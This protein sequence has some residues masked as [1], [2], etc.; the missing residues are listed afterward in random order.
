MDTAFG[1]FEEKGIIRRVRTPAGAK[2]YGQPIGT[3][4][5]LDA[6]S[7]G[8]S[9][10]GGGSGTRKPSRAVSKPTAASDGVVAASLDAATTQKRGSSK[11]GERLTR[12]TSPFKG[13]K[14]YK[15]KGKG[16]FIGK[17]PE[18]GKWT[19][20]DQDFNFLHEG[21]Y[22]GEVYMD[23]ED[24]L[25]ATPNRTVASIEA[26]NNKL[27]TLPDKPTKANLAEFKEKYGKPVPP[28]WFDIRLNLDGKGPLVATGV[29]AS[30]NRKWLYTADQDAAAQAAKW[31]RVRRLGE[32]LDKIDKGL[33]KAA[34][35]DDTAAAVLLMRKTGIRV[36]SSA[37]QRGKTPTYGV[38]TLQGRHFRINQN[39]VTLDFIGKESVQQHFVIKDPEVVA[40]FKAREHIKRNEPVFPDTNSAR[41]IKYISEKA[42]RTYKN[43]DLRTY[44]GNMMAHA[45]IEKWEKRPPKTK[46]EFLRKRR[47][48]ATAV[49]A[50]LGNNPAATLTSYINP[51]IWA[52]YAQEGWL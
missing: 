7:G 5:I 29:D 19:A 15:F 36:G 45:M 27:A 51:E 23:L 9:G 37:E 31:V 49:A 25:D 28:G 12:D 38:T 21:D 26:E 47:E 35:T 40:M 42:G 4:I 41:T 10:S 13:W 50:Q 48:I 52:P 6:P 20:V 14:K 3:I 1:D 34:L 33:A 2:R 18:T 24:D 44:L 30:G 17:D 8:R 32:D 22:E 43:H 39:S 46:T 11:R 16:Y